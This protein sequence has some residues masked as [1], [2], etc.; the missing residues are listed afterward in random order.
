MFHG[1]LPCQ[2][3]QPRRLP[4]Q[5]AASARQSGTPPADDTR[6][7][8]P[9]SVPF[10]AAQNGRSVLKLRLLARLGQATKSIPLALQALRLLIGG[11]DGLTTAVGSTMS[12]RLK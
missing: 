1:H 11:P 4:P 5:Y 2:S 6:A 12:G 9:P 10:K 7:F 3:I 8:T